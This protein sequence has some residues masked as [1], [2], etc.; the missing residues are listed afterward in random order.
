MINVVIADDQEV[1][2]E[3]IKLI[4]EQDP[5]IRVVGCAADGREAFE[6]CNRLNPDLVLMDIIMPGCDG[7]EGTRLIKS[8]YSSIKVVILTTF[9][10]MDKISK[11][12]KN[13]ADGYVLK[14]ITP[15]DL[16][17]LIKSTVNGLNVMHQN[18]FNALI[19]QFS[20]NDGEENVSTENKENVLT[21]REKD[22]VRLIIFGK[23][24]REIASNIHLSEGRI[25]NIITGILYKLQLKDRTQL[26]VYAIKN[27]LL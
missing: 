13:G 19:R 24:N 1:I 10:D 18:V 7:V 20:D 16:K 22:V 23:N 26:A 8:G 9:S 3:G 4:I 14:D 27:K 5:D 12:L 15:G 17:Q 11:A 6:L 25:K 2:R 21:D